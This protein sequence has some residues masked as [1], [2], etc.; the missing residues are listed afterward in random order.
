MDQGIVSG[1]FGLSP[2]E[3]EQ[4]RQ[5]ATD[6]AAAQYAQMQ[7]IQRAAMGMYQAGAGLGRIGAGMLGLQDP[8]VAEAQ[9]RRAMLSQLDPNDPNSYLKVAQATS[10]PKLRFQLMAIADQKKKE[11]IAAQQASTKMAL[12]LA[13][14]QKALRENPNLSVTEVGVKGRPGYMQK[15]IFDKTKPDAPYQ[16]IGEPY[17]SAAAAK[18]TFHVNTNEG[19][20]RSQIVTDNTGKSTLVNLDT[21]ETIK[22]LG[23]IGKPSGTY[24]KGEQAKKATLQGI[25]DAE[26]N[27]DLLLGTEQAP[28]LLYKAT[29]SGIGAAVDAGA[30][31]FGQ[32][33]AGD[34]ANAQIQPLADA[35]LKIVP[36]FEGPQSDKDTASYKEA[37]GNLANPNLPKG[38]K[39]AAAKTI[40]DIYARRKGQFVSKDFATEEIPATG[41]WA[42]RE[43]K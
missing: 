21:G 29:G 36:R 3:V 31:L 9:Q 43:K 10:D 11:A 15:V 23:V 18:Q 26:A 30:R 1:L 19:K 25:K 28:G 22:E 5:N 13:Q 40:K 27:I 37:A 17:L 34:I 24:E 2:Y 8:A 4:Q 12:E 16:E 39:I 42:I 41:G 7:P 6:A 38:L 20:V 32:S 14:A 35:V 33:T